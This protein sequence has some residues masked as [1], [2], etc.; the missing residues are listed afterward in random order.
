MKIHDFKDLP[1]VQKIHQTQHTGVFLT[2]TRVS[3]YVIKLYALGKFYVEIWY[4]VEKNEMDVMAFDNTE[5][6]AAYIPDIDFSA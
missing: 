5:W 6:L 4:D 1:L 3:D 2:V